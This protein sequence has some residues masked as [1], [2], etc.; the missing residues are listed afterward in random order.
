LALSSNALTTVAAVCAELSLEVPASGSAEEA[1]LERRIAA[2]S[3][4][5][6]RYCSR[7]FGQAERTERMEGFGGD[8]L[9]LRHAPVTE[10]SAITLDGEE[11]SLDE[12]ESPPAEGD[13]E[14]G[15]A[16]RLDGCWESTCGRR[17]YSVTYTA[18]WVLPKDATN[19]NQRTLPY[20][21]EHACI[22]TVVA[23]Y[24]AK[25]RDQAIVSESVLSASVTYAGSQTN[26]AIGR[27]AGG[28]IPDNAAALLS[29][30]RWAT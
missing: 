7:V 4:A 25:G 8:V 5:I 3:D 14:A 19:D 20:D 26:S 16:R 11:V 29:H 1:D 10:V 2:A 28:I 24:L 15:L 13:A 27:G 30:Y 9:F 21:V 12:V 18:G 22:L 23:D 6:A 17:S